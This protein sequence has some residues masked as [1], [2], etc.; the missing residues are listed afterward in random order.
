MEM[1]YDT[2]AKYIS[3]YYKKLFDDKSTIFVFE[4][5]EHL[6]YV[7]SPKNTLVDISYNEI[8]ERNDYLKQSAEI[9]FINKEHLHIT[10]SNLV[11]FTYTTQ[12]HHSLFTQISYITKYDIN[13]LSSLLYINEH[14]LIITEMLSSLPKR[15]YEKITKLITKNKYSLSLHNLLSKIFDISLNKEIRIYIKRPYN[16]ISIPIIKHY[17]TSK[18]HYNFTKQNKKSH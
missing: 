7:I 10:P 2:A 9:K 3:N 12:K 18:Q 8:Y 5:Y 13:L 11:T 17:I 4:D 6:Q 1:D 15:S 16:Y 14:I